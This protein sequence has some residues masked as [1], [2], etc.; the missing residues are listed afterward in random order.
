VTEWIARLWRR[1]TAAARRRA[2]EDGYRA[3]SGLDET[4][5]LV[6]RESAKYIEKEKATWKHRS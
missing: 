6:R 4:S 1:A 5:Q 2:F 3:A